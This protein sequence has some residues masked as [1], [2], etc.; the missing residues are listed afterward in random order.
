[1]LHCVRAVG[2]I[3][4]LLREVQLM[5]ELDRNVGIPIVM[6]HSYGGSPEGITQITRACAI[7]ATRGKK[8]QSRSATSRES[9]NAE[10][11]IRQTSLEHEVTR[12]ATWV[13]FG[14]SAGMLSNPRA[15][16]ARASAASCH[17]EQVLLE[18]D[19]PDQVP[20]PTAIERARTA[21]AAA[22]G[23]TDRIP[24]VKVESESC[25]LS[26]GAGTKTAAGDADADD[27][28]ILDLCSHD[29]LGSDHSRS[30]SESRSSAYACARRLPDPMDKGDSHVDS[31][32]KVCAPSNAQDLDH[33]LTS[34]AAVAAAGEGGAL[35]LAPVE[36]VEAPES[37]HPSPSA[38]SCSPP[39]PESQLSSPTSSFPADLNCP[40]NVIVALHALAELRGTGMVELA[41]AVNANFERTLGKYC[42]REASGLEFVATELKKCTFSDARI[43]TSVSDSSLR[44]CGGDIGASLPKQAVTVPG[45]SIKT[46]MKDEQR[47]AYQ[48][49]TQD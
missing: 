12:Q 32:G 44:C 19:A 24:P 49:G 2:A 21:W 4:D 17:L 40:S 6:I 31:D 20:S 9:G 23:A 46:Q 11:K 10:G 39:R 42:F 47:E 48:D 37:L 35:Q 18:T 28:G 33:G 5:G 7:V 14:F 29:E 45:V 38:S 27:G 25:S 34:A 41:A 26:R 16:K 13:M 3:A 43:R 30:R 36:C 15:K 1:M 8:K 22:L